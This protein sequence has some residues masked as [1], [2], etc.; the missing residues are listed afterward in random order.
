MPFT[1]LKTT[2]KDRS[3]SADKTEIGLEIAN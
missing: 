1:H 3:K 2:F